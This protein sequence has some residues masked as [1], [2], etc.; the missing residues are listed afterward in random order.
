MLAEQRR[1]LHVGRAVGHLDRIADGQVLAAR[2]VIDLDDGA[3]LAQR[4]LLGDLL[5]RQDRAARDVV[6]VEDVHRLELGLGLRPFLDLAEDLHQVR[7][8]RL[9]RRV[10]RIGQPFLAADHLA[11]GFPHRRLG[12]EVDVRVGIGFPALALEDPAGLAAARG[13]ARARHG[14]AERAVRILRVF[15]HDVRAREPLLVAQLHA[16]EIEHAVL[17]RREH[18]LAAAGGVALVERGDD[19][20]RQ[21]QAGVRCRRS[22]RR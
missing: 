1:A 8:A 5:H 9:R 22:A 7:Q 20:E 17:H 14:V 6:L 15:L 3:G 16:A 13:V 21:M 12:D 19:A 11:D 10:A 2:R 4:R 18:A